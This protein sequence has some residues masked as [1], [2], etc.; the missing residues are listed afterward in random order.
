MVDSLSRRDI[1]ILRNISPI[2]IIKDLVIEPVNEDFKLSIPK[3][4]A[5]PEI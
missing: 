4:K 1:K 2:S 5:M 3:I